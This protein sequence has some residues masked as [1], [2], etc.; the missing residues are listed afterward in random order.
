M[1]CD[2]DDTSSRLWQLSGCSHYRP[3]SL[4]PDSQIIDI[5]VITVIC[6][7]F[8]D[9]G[10]P[11]H[12]EIFWKRGNDKHGLQL[13][14]ALKRFGW[15]KICRFHPAHLLL[16]T[17]NRMKS[18]VGHFTE[19]V[20]NVLVVSVLTGCEYPNISI[21]ALAYTDKYIMGPGHHG[22]YYSYDADRR[23]GSGG[24][25]QHRQHLDFG[26][27]NSFLRHANICL[28]RDNS[29]YI[30]TKNTPEKER[31][32]IGQ[33]HKRTGLLYPISNSAFHSYMIK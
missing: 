1:T 23:H 12:Q 5:R 2:D 13:F 20:I 6:G 31:G 15:Q 29:L 22:R 33:V 28:P 9:P 26:S 14:C 8:R 10:W 11:E 16:W 7:R 18:L 25:T 24:S 17:L 4:W 19:R 27:W 30:W 21:R 3:G 32:K